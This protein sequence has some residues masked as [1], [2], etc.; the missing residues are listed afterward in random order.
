MNCQQADEFILSYCDGELAA[1]QSSELESH[2]ALCG[3]CQA[4]VELT[5]M[6]TDILQADLLFPSLPDG[7]SAGVIAAIA[8]NSLPGTDRSISLKS[9][10]PWYTRTPLWL[11]ATAAAFVLLVYTVSPG[12]FSPNTPTANK[13][14]TAVKVADRRAVTNAIVG[15]CSSQQMEQSNKEK[16]VLDENTLE[17]KQITQPEDLAVDESGNQVRTMT[18]AAPDETNNKLMMKRDISPDRDRTDAIMLKLPAGVTFDNSS[19]PKVTNMPS[20]YRMISSTKQVDGWTYIYEGNEKQI[21]VSLASNSQPMAR[22]ASPEAPPESPAA[23]AGVA[24][25]S[26]YGGTLKAASANSVYR[27]V[28][29]EDVY[30]QMTVSA[31]LSVEELNTLAGK[32]TVEK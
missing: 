12:I 9:K 17:S 4:K 10:R 25:G 15:G 19:A 29:I 16:T 11:A 31:E 30:Y 1:F 2:L 5:R 7:F 26:E 21:T 23:A 20:A 14:S 13:Q 24:S 27:S 8:K 6:E 32:L 18:G 3:A 22:T 28:K